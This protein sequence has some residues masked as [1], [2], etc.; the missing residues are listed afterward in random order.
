MKRSEPKLNIRF[1]CS[2][3][4]L[5]GKLVERGESVQMVKRG[6]FVKQYNNYNFLN[7]KYEN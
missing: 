2:H 4:Q 6:I 5:I 7:I 3:F 1:V